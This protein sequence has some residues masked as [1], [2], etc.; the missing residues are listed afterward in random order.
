MN[1]V[2]EKIGVND[3]LKIIENYNDTH[4]QPTLPEI[5][6]KD[7][8]LVI[9]NVVEIKQQISDDV[10]QILTKWGHI[11]RLKYTSYERIIIL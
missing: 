6:L 9:E 1:M 3:A 11:I 10:V 8:D 2:V 7:V 4:I 5:S